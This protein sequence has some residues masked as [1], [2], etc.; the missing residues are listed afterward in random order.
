LLG[1]VVVEL[2]GFAGTTIFPSIF[3]IIV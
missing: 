1:F 3:N 2:A